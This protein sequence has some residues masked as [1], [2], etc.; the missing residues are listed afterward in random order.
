MNIGQ[1]DVWKFF[2]GNHKHVAV[3]VSI[4]FAQLLQNF[5]ELTNKKINTACDGHV[6]LTLNEINERNRVSLDLFF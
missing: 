3:Q 4:H 6:A 5:I 1:L 2:T